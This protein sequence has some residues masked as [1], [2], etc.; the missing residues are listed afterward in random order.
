M[1]IATLIKEDTY[2]GLAYSVVHYHHGSTVARRQSWCW[3]GSRDFYI[4]IDRDQEEKRNNEAWLE[5]LNSQSPPHSDKLPPKRPHLL[6]V[7]L[8]MGLREPFSLGSSQVGRT[9]VCDCQPLSR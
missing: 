5:H 1:D 6:T 9:Y 4:W 2:L 3:R 7:P 8:L